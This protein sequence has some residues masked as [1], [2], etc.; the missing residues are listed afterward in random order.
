MARVPAHVDA[1]ASFEPRTRNCAIGSRRIAAQPA[2]L[3]RGAISRNVAS[4]PVRSGLVMTS[5]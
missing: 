2:L 4:R 1:S 3:D 5:D